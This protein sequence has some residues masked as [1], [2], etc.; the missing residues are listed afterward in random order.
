M[1]TLARRRRH[2]AHLFVLPA[3]LTLA[4][5][6]GWPLLRSVYLAFTDSTLNAPDHGFVGGL[7]PAAARRL[8]GRRL[9]L[10]GLH[11]ALPDHRPV[12]GRLRHRGQGEDR[13][14]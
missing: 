10:G 3:L 6:A 4:L 1:T 9:R 7:R 8:P 13:R 12:H 5:V 14:A 11:L 2:Q